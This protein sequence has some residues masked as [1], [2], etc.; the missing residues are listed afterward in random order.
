MGTHKSPHAA[1]SRRTSPQGA[2]A[3]ATD[4][5]SVQA[6]QHP[7]V[8]L[9]LTR[10]LSPHTIAHVQRAAGNQAVLRMLSQP[11]PAPVQRTGVGTI[12]REY[13]PSAKQTNE[14]K[15]ALAGWV[16]GYKKSGGETVADLAKDIAAYCDNHAQAMVII[17]K[18]TFEQ[19]DAVSGKMTAEALENQLLGLGEEKPKVVEKA[20]DPLDTVR[21]KIKAKGWD[22]KL[23]GVDDLTQ[24]DTNKGADGWEKALGDTY[25]RLLEAKQNAD[26]HY[27]VVLEYGPTKTAGD[28]VF[29]NGILAAVWNLGHLIATSPTANINTT[30]GGEYPDAT[31]LAAANIWQA[32]P[33]IGLVTGL[34]VPGGNGA[35]RIQDKSTRPVKP[36]LTRGRQC[37]FI[38][39][40]K[41]NKIN[42]HVNSDVHH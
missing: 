34:H 7:A 4:A 14:L 27:K 32:S 5:E 15:G 40:W 21:Q 19:W 33:Q 38:S 30:I 39:F 8:S 29:T 13:D 12:Q 6:Y 35:G 31:I 2:P 22:L 41:G 42:V 9:S 25:Q 3:H 10:G 17:G 16:R 1:A 37:D 23:F 24:I 18:M 11:T 36:D 20:K 28:L 26:L